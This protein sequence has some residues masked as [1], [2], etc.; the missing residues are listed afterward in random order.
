MELLFV[1]TT[2]ST[3]LSVGFLLFF[4]FFLPSLQ[5]KEKSKQNNKLS[6]VWM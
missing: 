4:F 1:L 3:V 5:N 2:G 6:R